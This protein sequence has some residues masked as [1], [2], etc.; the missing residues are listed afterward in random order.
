[1]AADDFTDAF[2]YPIIKPYEVHGNTV[3]VLS[4]QS[5]CKGLKCRVQIPCGVTGRKAARAGFVT[6]KR[7]AVG[8]PVPGDLN[9]NRDFHLQERLVRPPQ[10]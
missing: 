2:R 10:K 9:D 7:R 3:T 5:G 8:R 4:L 1:M 6:G